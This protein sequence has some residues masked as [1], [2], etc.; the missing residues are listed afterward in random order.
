[1]PPSSTS[2]NAALQRPPERVV[3]VDAPTV[4][5]PSASSSAS[6]VPSPPSATGHRSGG[7][8]P[9]RSSPRPIA[10][11]TSAARN[12]PLNESGA[13]STGR[14]GTVAIAAS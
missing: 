13:T 10:P 7:I 9:A 5:P 1:M 6:I 11:A 2:P 14:S 3:H 8:R 4:S 12:V